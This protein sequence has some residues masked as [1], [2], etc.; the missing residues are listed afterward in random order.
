[1]KTALLFLFLFKII[2]VAAQYCCT[3]A[4]KKHT[5]WEVTFTTSVRKMA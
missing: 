5:F 4:I 3:E 2:P 1:M